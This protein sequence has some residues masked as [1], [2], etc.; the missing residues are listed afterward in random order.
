MAD[1]LTR[2]GRSSAAR[3][4]LR[5]S[6]L[7]EPLVAC[8]SHECLLAG[9]A[10][11][12]KPRS[13]IAAAVAPL[14]AAAAAEFRP[15]KDVFQQLHDAAARIAQGDTAGAR[16]WASQPAVAAQ[17]KRMVDAS[18]ALRG[19]SDSGVGASP[20]GGRISGRLHLDGALACLRADVTFLLR[21]VHCGQLLHGRVWLG[22]G[23]MV[24]ASHDPDACIALARAY[25]AEAIA[26][27]L[28]LPPADPASHSRS[29]LALQEARFCVARRM[30]AAIAHADGALHAARGSSRGSSGSSGDAHA[31]SGAGGAETA[32]GTGSAVDRAAEP[33]AAGRRVDLGRY[34]DD[35]SPALAQWVAAEVLRCACAI[36]GVS[37]AAPLQVVASA[38]DIAAP[39]L[40]HLA[41]ALKPT[42]RAWEAL[43]DTAGAGMGAEQ[44]VD[45][46]LH[47]PLSMCFHSTF[48]DPVSRTNVDTGTNAPLL[49]GCGHV[50]ARES[51]TRLAGSA[52]GLQG[53]FKC[54]TCPYVQGS[55]ASALELKL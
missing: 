5:E 14:D 50:L 32:A 55:L 21:L 7:A 2:T 29:A 38:A 26:P 44:V 53:A 22:P 25:A 30:A 1:Y 31:T 49:L 36:A 52:R 20:A 13:S 11:Q 9:T 23:R 28:C 4:V 17:L 10:E 46:D 3:C 54:P 43:Y 8:P 19:L 40:A 41:R 33:A 37:P 27:L 39:Y 15:L 6:G 18:P 34:A 35:A 42:A 51:A 24:A 47:L 48:V 12:H 16:A 45:V